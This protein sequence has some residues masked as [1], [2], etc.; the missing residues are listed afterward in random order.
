MA[1]HK[2]HWM[3][4]VPHRTRDAWFWQ[5]SGLSMR[6][7][8]TY[9][10]DYLLWKNENRLSSYISSSWNELSSKV[11]NTLSINQIN[12]CVAFRE[13]TW[14]KVFISNI[15]LFKGW[16]LIVCMRNV[17]WYIWRYNLTTCATTSKLCWRFVSS[18]VGI[19]YIVF[20]RRDSEVRIFHG[21]S[22]TIFWIKAVNYVWFQKI[23]MPVY[24]KR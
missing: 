11:W 23:Y 10:T 5:F 13:K 4:A 17:D 24:W 15:N 22:D 2:V 18:S 14:D 9:M 8:L 12:K 20:S 16:W 1:G 19:R 21:K 7:W 3:C 6:H